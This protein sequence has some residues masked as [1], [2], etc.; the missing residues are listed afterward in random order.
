MFG[1]K[2]VI[3]MTYKGKKIVKNCLLCKNYCK[4]PCECE[5][6]EDYDNFRISENGKHYIK[7]FL[8]KVIKVNVKNS[9][10]IPA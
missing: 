6:C 1:S 2:E 10:L 8:N 7:K 3:K 5:H 9:E 4:H